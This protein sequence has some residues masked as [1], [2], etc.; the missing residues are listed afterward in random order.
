MNQKI[1][2]LGWIESEIQIV[3][4]KTSSDL[5]MLIKQHSR[6]SPIL[7]SLTE[8]FIIY[9]SMFFVEMAQGRLERRKPHLYKFLKNTLNIKIT[10][11]IQVCLI[12][13][14]NS[15]KIN[16][17]KAAMEILKK[18]PYDLKN[19]LYS[20]LSANSNEEILTN[21]NKLTSYEN[22]DGTCDCKPEMIKKSLALRRKSSIDIDEQFE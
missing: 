4:P 19:L 10:A 13:L 9:L 15:M 18:S 16:P 21:G 11:L 20:I 6:N 7:A 17:E 14:E 3:D 12:H 5:R 8:E 1:L 2:T 22:G